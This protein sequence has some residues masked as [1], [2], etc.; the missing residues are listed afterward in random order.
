MNHQRNF[1]CASS[2]R[3]CCK[4]RYP[5]TALFCC[6]FPVISV[7]SLFIIIAQF[8]ADI[9]KFELNITHTPR[10]VPRN[11]LP[12]HLCVTPLYTLYSCVC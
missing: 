12:H 11:L 5:F 7:F 9:T 8:V 10:C 6:C 3:C 1:H 4:L 2:S